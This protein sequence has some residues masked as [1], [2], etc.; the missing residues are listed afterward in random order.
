MKILG[1]FHDFRTFFIGKG[2][3]Y[4]TLGKVGI[5]PALLLK[6]YP[7]LLENEWNALV[8]DLCYVKSL[9]NNSHIERN[10][11]TILQIGF[12]PCVL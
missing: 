1:I 7:F 11:N 9:I 4:Q 8:M 10:N 6:D 3:F 12:T 2:S 5:I